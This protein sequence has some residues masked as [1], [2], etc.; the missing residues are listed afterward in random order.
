M[1]VLLS[2]TLLWGKDDGIGASYVQ[3][4]QRGRCKGLKIYTHK[5]L[6]NCQGHFTES[7]RP[8]TEKKNSVKA[9]F[10]RL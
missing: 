7:L 8:N 6:Q 9:T 4:P 2:F 5:V 1:L 10:L 3:L